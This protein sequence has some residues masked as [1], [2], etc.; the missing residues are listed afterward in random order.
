MDQSQMILV[1]SIAIA[2]FFIFCAFRKKTHEIILTLNPQQ[3]CPFAVERPMTP[4][5]TATEA[6]Q[7]IPQVEE[8]IPPIVESFSSL[9]GSSTLKISPL[10]RNRTPV[11]NPI[12]R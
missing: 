6:V 1:A 3:A 2:L 5:P 4:T 12:Y 11:K 9:N 8:P 10:M 7:V